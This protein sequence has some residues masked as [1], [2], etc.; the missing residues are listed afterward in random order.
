MTGRLPS[1][2]VV[3]AMKCGTTALHRYLGA[4]PQISMAEVK[5]ANFFI[6]PD[7]APHADE[8]EWWR[9]GN[10]HRG[11][12]WYTSLFDADA[13]VRGE[14]SPGYTSPDS[15]VAA[16]RMAA[17]V[18]QA[19]LVYL[20]RDPVDRAVSQYAHHVRDGTEPRPVAEA[21]LDPASQYVGRSRFHERLEPYLDRFDRDQVLVVV[22]ERLRT[23]RRAE[24]RKVFAHVGADPGF[25]SGDLTASH[26]MGGV[27]TDV[28]DSL[29]AR[30]LSLVA[31]DVD[32][33]RTLTDD[34]I[35]EWRA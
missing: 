21:L 17:V 24:L 9:T 31:D 2:I 32:R 14:T 1:L 19:R 30:F 29:R 3:G 15:V 12:G 20:V 6:G 25:W 34:A 11:V 16:E 8:A 13:P 5:E 27:A 7:V 18:P 33:L 10:W 22:S 4:H 23:H 28:D 26:H 35:P